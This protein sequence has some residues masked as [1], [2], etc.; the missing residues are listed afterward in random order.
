MVKQL[1]KELEI[2]NILNVDTY[3]SLVLRLK[4]L[5]FLPSSPLFLLK[6]ISIAFL[7]NSLLWET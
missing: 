6:C 5:K 7:R 3:P 1:K 2:K 4:F